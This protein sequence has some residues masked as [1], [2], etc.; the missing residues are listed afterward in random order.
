LITLSWARNATRRVVLETVR[1]FSADR[2]PDLAASLAFATLL[3]AVP[4]AA[5]FSLLLATF[6][7]QNDRA[8][9]EIFRIILPDRA[10]RVTASVQ[11]FIDSARAVSG[12]GLV[13]LLATS[14]RLIFVIENTV[15]VVWGAPKRKRWIARVAVYTLGLF[16]GALLIGVLVTG[17]NQ[18]KRQILIENLLSSALFGRFA[19]TLVV[20]AALTLLYKFLPNARVTWVAAAVGGA[21]VSL[22][23]RVIKVGFALY[24]SVFD[25]INIVYGSLSLVFLSLIFLFLFWA[26]VLLGVEL[27]YVLGA[28]AGSHAARAGEGRV[29][30]GVRLL[31]SLDRR[32]APARLE[33][34]H[35]EAGGTGAEVAGLLAQLAADGLLREERG[36]GF[37]LAERLDRIPLARVVSA[38]SPEL[39]AVTRENSDRI[40]RILRRLFR[41]L[42][43][44]ERA[45]LDVT[46]ADLAGRR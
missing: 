18:L 11:E 9:L 44:E 30:R 1:G 33:E 28:T 19:S 27:T 37:A 31:V 10:G 15:N 5:T 17:L 41:K 36:R 22:S 46:L 12:I 45:L 6:F 24:F 39:L 7:R 16:V 14:L 20:G 25:D 26:L 43:A 32:Q 8:I 35:R 21:I 40:A 34:I 13:I 4:L 29:E 2:G 38:V 42:L 23:L 3:M